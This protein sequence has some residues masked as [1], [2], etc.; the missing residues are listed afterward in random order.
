[1]RVGLPSEA[2]SCPWSARGPR[3]PPERRRSGLAHVVARELGLQV[4]R[5]ANDDRQGR[6]QNPSNSQ[7]FCAPAV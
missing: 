5:G 7:W 2:S 6:R 1:M 3:D 4:V